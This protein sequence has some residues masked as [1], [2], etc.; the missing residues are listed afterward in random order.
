MPPPGRI[1]RGGAGRL[2]RRT[3]LPG[4]RPTRSRA[5]RPR[6]GRRGTWSSIADGVGTTMW[7]RC[8]RNA[9]AREYRSPAASCYYPADAAAAPVPGI[10]PIAPVSSP[11]LLPRDWDG[12]GGSKASGD[13][14]GGELPPP[15]SSR[16][17]SPADPEWGVDRAAR[18]TIRRG[19]LG[20]TSG[21]RGAKWGRGDD[22]AD[23]DTQ[24]DEDDI[25]G[26]TAEADDAAAADDGGAAADDGGAAASSAGAR[27]SSP[28]SAAPPTSRSWA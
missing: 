24:D 1:R 21:G 2:V 7:G 17:S 4:A 18:D 20:G 22:G 13:D 26:G 6:L 19:I 28:L 16:R 11:L 25:P 15:P 9:P 14:R 27:T 10:D 23:R 8:W 12:R 5:R 3:P